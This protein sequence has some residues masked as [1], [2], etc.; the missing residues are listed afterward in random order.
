MPGW[1]TT[2]PGGSRPARLRLRHDGGTVFDMHLYVAVINDRHSDPDPR[3]FFDLSAA[4]AVAR[5]YALECTPEPG[6]IDEEPVDSHLYSVGWGGEGDCAWVVQRKVHAS[7][8]LCDEVAGM[9]VTPHRGC[10]LR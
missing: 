9:H 6:V 4:V 3:L 10:V 2:T 8:P 1:T 7:V 5:G